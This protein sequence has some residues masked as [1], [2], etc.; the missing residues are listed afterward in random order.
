MA[1]DRKY[2]NEN[3]AAD[4]IYMRLNRNNAKR[5][6]ESARNDQNF[7]RFIFNAQHFQ[8]KGSTVETVGNL[9][10]EIVLDLNVAETAAPGQFRNFAGKLPWAPTDAPWTP[11]SYRQAGPQL[12]EEMAALATLHSSTAVDAVLA[13][14]HMLGDA[15]EAWLDVD[16]EHFELMRQKLD[17]RQAHRVC[18]DYPIIA[19]LGRFK[20][21]AWRRRVMDAIAGLPIST[22]W[23]R[24]GSGGDDIVGSVTQ[25]IDS[26]NEFRSL[27]HPI[28]L[29]MAGDL[30]AL[31][32]LAGGGV[33]AL[34]SSV[35][36]GGGFNLQAWRRETRPPSP[37]QRAYLPG[38]DARLTAQEW[39]DFFFP[40]AVDGNEENRN[41]H[42]RFFS[43]VSSGCCSDAP[44]VFDDVNGHF[45]RQ[46]ALQIEEI[47]AHA[48]QSGRFLAKTYLGRL[49]SRMRALDNLRFT[50][51]T[52]RKKIDRF[53]KKR[54]RLEESLSKHPGYLNASLQP[55]APHRALP[56][57]QR[58]LCADSQEPRK[59]RRRKP[60]RPK[61]AKPS[62][63]RDTQTPDLF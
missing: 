51:A 4:R 42:H 29:D 54:S 23:L 6:I 20:D 19:P 13:P 53:E 24:I 7:K 28:V 14:T 43:C 50:E 56:A 47:E 62:A 3:S 21:P 17:E 15:Q 10:A 22:L 33:D 57:T 26:T 8:S 37:T 48:D 46:R 59:S 36:R 60:G 38:I 58:P 30:V 63:S 44:S 11:E 12:L 16:I 61:P 55:V 25:I 18:L 31:C 34:A 40:E 52:L 49:Q 41:I 39:Q 9:G 2:S 32:V 5:T 35:G 27:G 45:T 1:E